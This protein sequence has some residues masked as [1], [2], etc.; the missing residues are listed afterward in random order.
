[1]AGVWQSQV[2]V[3]DGGPLLLL[4]PHELLGHWEGTQ[5]DYERACDARYPFDF[6]PVG[7][8]FGVIVSGLGGMVYDAYWL[9]LPRRPGVIFVG[10]EMGE[11]DATQRLMEKLRTGQLSWHRYRRRMAV[12]SGVLF[13]QH[14]AGPG[15]EVLMAPSDKIACI[16]QAVP[17]GM[18]PG[19]YALETASVQEEAGNDSYTCVLC[20]WIPT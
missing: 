1:M 10:W 7:P 3:N 12:P 8:G 13:L 15:T 17:V 9:R 19:K 4:L 11:E 14:A 6:F 18:A 5:G 20:R 2:F 16:G